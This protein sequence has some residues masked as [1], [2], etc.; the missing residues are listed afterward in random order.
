MTSG[1]P[2]RLSF[3][4]TA[5]HDRAARSLAGLRPSPRARAASSDIPARPDQA[6]A[7]GRPA[8]DTGVDAAPSRRSALALHFPEPLESEFR[9]DFDATGRQLRGELW[10]GLLLAIA[11]LLILD[12]QL[13]NTTRSF[14]FWLAIIAGVIFPALLRWL[15]TAYSPVR[16]WSAACYIAAV[17]LDVVALMG[18]R[19]FGLHNG[20]DMVPILVPTAVLSS[21]IVAQIR[22]SAL[23]P[24]VA[25]GLAM[26][27]AIELAYVP[28]TSNTLFDLVSC[29]ILA[30]VPLALAHQLE[31]AQRDAWLQ[32]RQLTSLNQ[33]DAL[34]LLPNRRA[35]IEHLT[36][37]IDDPQRSPTV[38]IIDLDDFKA[39]NDTYGHPVGDEYLRCIGAYLATAA[40]APGVFAARLSGEEFVIVHDDAGA[41]AQALQY[42][43][44]LR[45]GIGGLA[46]EHPG[47]GLLAASAGCTR[48]R[49]EHDGVEMTAID[50]IAAADEALYAAKTGGRD[51]TRFT[52]MHVPQVAGG[53]S[54]IALPTDPVAPIPLRAG[55]LQMRFPRVAEHA[56]QTTF[57]ASGIPLR[58]TIMIAVFTVCVVLLVIAEPVLRIPEQARL[59]GNLTLIVALIPASLAAVIATLVP[60]LRPR[61]TGFFVVAI[62]VIIGSQMFQR[63]VLLPLGH[64]TVPFLMPMA[65]LLSMG[66]VLIR[67]SL[68][69]P[70]MM[71]TT[72][73]LFTTELIAFPITVSR[74]VTLVFASV[75]VLAALR[76]AYRIEYNRRL[77]WER[78]LRLVRLIRTDVITGLPNRRQFTEVLSA[79]LTA[80][81]STALTLIDVDG[82]KSYNDHF[83]HVAGDECLRLLGQMITRGAG[84]GALVAR[85]GGEEFAVVFRD[86][87]PEASQRRAEQIIDAV[88]DA[89]IPA[90]PG[91]GI[92]TISAG[93]AVGDRHDSATTPD[94]AIEEL[95]AEAD[96]ALYAAKGSGR[97]RVVYAR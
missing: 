33:T 72:V 14:Y 54:R 26:I 50:V 48:A 53:Q 28:V 76:F 84:A 13:L 95:L 90:A 97:D 88:R 16:R 22:F 57:D 11:A 75:M 67:F 69:L 42:A 70:A 86:D 77:D 15:S 5:R 12:A 24:A 17:Y 66:I 61:S 19:V 27:L 18:V 45:A 1:P 23:V 73:G 93:L 36:A 96:R 47:G 78:T 60:R 41:D 44:A 56:F 34:T 20:V 68:L 80:Q 55:L 74:C 91:R 31:R 63:V 43:E 64:E 4:K 29:A 49:G 30:A 65:V 40:H 35:L 94:A 58:R 8:S 89:A 7:S 51:Q 79:C 21:L 83:G 82:F 9:V 39:V 52:P 81:P 37:A 62:V 25:A 38:T 87:G 2:P 10:I 59:I 6:S 92:V 85:L 3:R 32:Q 46:L 71:A